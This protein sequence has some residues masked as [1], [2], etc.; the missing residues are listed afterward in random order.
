MNP[1]TVEWI[2]KAEGDYTSSGREWRLRCGA[3]QG[4][5]GA[6]KGGSRTAPTIAL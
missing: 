1:L 6:L 3:P 4:V 5:C 2:D